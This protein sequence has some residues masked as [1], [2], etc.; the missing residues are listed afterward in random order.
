MINA[1]VAYI[2]RH[3]KI[4]VLVLS[5]NSDAI[6]LPLD[7]LPSDIHLGQKLEITIK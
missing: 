1:E 4:A 3:H 2:D 7:L 6:M 5:P